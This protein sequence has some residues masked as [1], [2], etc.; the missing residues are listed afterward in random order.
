MRCAGLN[1]VAAVSLTA[2][3]EAQL[4]ISLP[5]TLAFDY[6]TMSAMAEYIA[7]QDTK[8]TVTDMAGAEEFGPQGTAAVTD[9]TNIAPQSGKIDNAPPGM[10]GYVAITAMVQRAPGYGTQTHT[11]TRTHIHTHLQLHIMAQLHRGRYHC[12]PSCYPT[13]HPLLPH[14]SVQAPGLVVSPDI[15]HRGQC[16]PGP[17]LPHP[18]GAVGCGQQGA[19]S[20]Q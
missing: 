13:Q 8:L 19:A 6:P 11:R 17:S 2:T 1:S 12:V 20:G 7:T 4:G 14:A 10:S 16:P 15:S 5:P 3:L 9:V 18:T